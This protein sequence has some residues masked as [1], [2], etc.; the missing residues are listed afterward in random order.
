[1]EGGDFQVDSD[2]ATSV[3]IIINELLQNS[4]KYAFQDR[5]SGEIR[6]VVEQGKLYSSIQV[7]DNGGGFDVA[8]TEGNRLG[9]VHRADVGEG[10]AA[11]Q[12][13]DR[14]GPRGNLRQ[15]RL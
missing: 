15:I 4:L 2:I 12:P 7:S 6:I 11:G 13:G 1:M 3:A 10:Q 5:S 8:N 9:A 14:V